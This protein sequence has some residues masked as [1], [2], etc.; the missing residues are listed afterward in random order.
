MRSL[1][2]FALLSL[3]SAGCTLAQVLL[4]PKIPDRRQICTAD[5][6]TGVWELIM[7]ERVYTKPEPDFILRAAPEYK[8]QWQFLDGRFSQI[9]EKAARDPEDEE[10]QFEA[11]GGEYTL[12][13][14]RLILRANL[15]PY[16]FPLHR[17]STYKVRVTGDEL[18]LTGK[19]VPIVED[20]SE[21]TQTILLRRVQSKS[22]E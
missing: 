10:F 13:D 20:M 11:F 7:I 8:G 5:E 16:I 22:P 15:S 19:F 9:V 12:T 2:I 4:A 21:G 18:R 3:L 1:I 6:I 17:P 14:G